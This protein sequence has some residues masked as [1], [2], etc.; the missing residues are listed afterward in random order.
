MS[1]FGYFPGT[2]LDIDVEVGGFESLG[3]VGGNL[4]DGLFEGESDDSCSAVSVAV[5]GDY[6]SFSAVEAV[7]NFVSF[8]DNLAIFVV[9]VAAS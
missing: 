6:D 9:D 2:A 1:G 3:F 4:G 8:L 7:L 5:D